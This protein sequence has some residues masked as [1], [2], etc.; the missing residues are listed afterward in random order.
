MIISTTLV[1][2][3]HLYLGMEFCHAHSICHR[4]LK[5]E[6]LLLDENLN[7]KIADF[8]MGKLAGQRQRRADADAADTRVIAREP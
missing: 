2:I 7:I 5:P 1:L 3:S 6:N 8:G 4:D